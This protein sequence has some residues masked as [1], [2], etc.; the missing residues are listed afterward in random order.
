MFS[1]QPAS[2]YNEAEI[3]GLL[4]DIYHVLLRQGHFAEHDL[5]WPPPEG[6]K[7][8]LSGLDD[9]CRID[10]QVLSLMRHLPV[11]ISRDNNDQKSLLPNLHGLKYTDPEILAQT[12]DIDSWLAAD[13]YP[14]SPV[15][16]M[17][18][19]LPTVLLLANGDFDSL[20]LDIADSEPRCLSKPELPI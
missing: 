14:E 16:D 8:D 17:T 13:P 10:L 3:V 20:V 2:Q 12:R 18:N 4:C 1:P 6:H 11:P 9:D 19:A 7:L 5:I 15:Y